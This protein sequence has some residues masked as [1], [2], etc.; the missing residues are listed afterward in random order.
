MSGLEPNFGEG[1]SGIFKELRA[2]KQKLNETFE[3]KVELSFDEKKIGEGVSQFFAAQLPAGKKIEASKHPTAFAAVNA[4]FDE[5]DPRRELM[6]VVRDNYKQLLRNKE[7]AGADENQLMD[8]AYQATVKGTASPNLEGATVEDDIHRYKFKRDTALFGGKNV[9][10]APGYDEWLQREKEKPIEDRLTGYGEAAAWWAGGDAAFHVLKKPVGNAIG[11]ALLATGV[12][13][14]QGIGGTLARVGPPQAKLL[15]TV[16]MAAAASVPATYLGNAVKKTDW[17]KAREDEPVKQA[18]TGI[19]VELLTGVGAMRG[20][21][22]QGTGVLKMAAERGAVTEATMRKFMSDQSASNI[23]AVAAARKAEKKALGE[24]SNLLTNVASKGERKAWFDKLNADDANFMKKYTDDYAVES[25]I[26]M[27]RN[28]LDEGLKLKSP[29]E[30]RPFGWEGEANQGTI[31][32][33]PAKPTIRTLSNFDDLGTPQWQ[34]EGYK[35]ATVNSKLD[36]PWFDDQIGTPLHQQGG[37]FEGYPFGQARETGT[38][39]A[40][41]SGQQFGLPAG[42]GQQMLPPSGVFGPKGQWSVVSRVENP[43]GGAGGGG[44]FGLSTKELP[45]KTVVGKTPEGNPIFGLNRKTQ[46]KI[47]KSL[48]DEQAVLVTDQ[49]LNGGK[50]LEEALEGM[51]KTR[52]LSGALKK[53]EDAIAVAKPKTTV[54]PPDNVIGYEGAGAAAESGKAAKVLVLKREAQEAG[55]ELASRAVAEQNAVRSS[56]EILREIGRG[57]APKGKEAMVLADDLADEAWDEQARAVLSYLGDKSRRLGVAVPE[58]RVAQLRAA[59]AK[60]VATPTEKVNPRTVRAEQKVADASQEMSDFQ[61]FT[62]GELD[63]ASYLKS[64][65]SPEFRAAEAEKI[66][67]TLAKAGVPDEKIDTHRAFETWR[68]MV[69]PIVEK[70]LEVI[71]PVADDLADFGGM[72]TGDS[73]ILKTLIPAGV[74]GTLSTAAVLGLPDDSHASVASAIGEAAARGIKAL[75]KAWFSTIAQSKKLASISHAES[76]KVFAKLIKEADEAGYVAKVVGT[77]KTLPRRM[78]TPNFAALAKE[79]YGSTAGAV[80]TVKALPLGIERLMG[81]WGRGAIHYNTGANPAVHLA[82]MQTAWTNNIENSFTVLHNIMK[83]VKGGA[84]A[85]REVAAMFK[86][87]AEEYSGVVTTHGIVTTKLRQL[88]KAL[89]VLEKAMKDPKLDAVAKEALQ[90]KYA[91]K[92]KELEA[93]NTA[94]R[95]KVGPAYEKFT[96]Q[97]EVLTKQAAQK[98]PSTRIFLAANDTADHQYYPWLKDLLT[99]EEKVAATHVKA[100]MK[101]YEESAVA[102]GLNVITDRPYMHY[103][104]HPSWQEARAAEYAKS[105][106][107]DLPVT[108]V[109][110]NQFHSRLVGAQPMV[111]DVYHSIQSYVPMAEKTLGWR[112]FWNKNGPKDSSWYKHMQS[113]TVQ[114][115]S[116][117]RG[118]WNAIKDASLPAEQMMVDKW[119]DRYTSFEVL[120]LLGG[121]PSVAY[122]HFFKNI[123]TWGSLGFKEAVSHMGTAVTTAARNKLMAPESAKYLSKLGIDTSKISKK[124]YDDAA[125]SFT[126]QARRINVL[127]DLELTP[128]SQVGWFDNMLQQVNHKAGFMVNA[129]ESYDRVHSFLAAGEMAAKRG[130]TGRDASYAI[131]DTILKNNFLGGV[132]NPSWAKSPLVRATMLFQSTA[133]K[134]FERRLITLHQSGRAVTEAFKSAKGTNWTWDKAFEEMKTLK[135]FIRKGEYEFKKGI[136]TDALASERDFLGQFSVRQSMREM[137]YAGVVLGGGAAMGHD[138]SHHIAHLPFVGTSQNGEP[139]VGLSPIAR[140]LWDTKEGKVYGGEESEFGI[141][142]DFLNNWF[143]GQ[144]PIPQMIHKGM[145]IAADDIPERYREEGFLPQEFRYFWAIP[146]TKEK[147]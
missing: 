87:L 110:Y 50:S 130:L 134:I 124:F 63:E 90:T 47:F 100:M 93:F 42:Q 131:Y 105:V 91:F 102:S 71:T 74:I 33:D 13:G 97:H 45:K 56:A 7:Y 1:D 92:L 18:L 126:N 144:G 9:A 40:L 109:P 79:L 60:G 83:D 65:E 104:W 99:S 70:E 127:D 68:K 140:A 73:S 106:G 137:L 72:T 96:A 35:P 34:G 117:M 76:Q 119:M 62:K 114:N 2:R 86:P 19:G 16:L 98:F 103:S 136:I 141:A 15:G 89:P 49:V 115:N 21:A 28:A 139:I 3:K 39:L 36:Q 6:P 31:F 133:F 8:L 122:K 120:R 29:V 57:I 77:S 5:D 135:D 67:N 107:I 85:A 23:M 138:Y 95:E 82:A 54:L 59:K 146:S 147:E 20:I 78:I 4:A 55:E 44:I 129:V 27:E 108:T 121:S 14:L 51:A 116:A 48:D 26:Q 53:T 22:K 24:M 81:P 88:N 38:Q 113:S 123:G 94:L 43:S 46:E 128:A 32:K 30:G 64:L 12:K 25:V 61:R 10:A 132:L 17:Y 37:A 66:Y 11:K 58:E 125:K 101:S 143:R 52:A 69:K 145:R 41:P 142:G 111:P 80:K 118:M 84:S 112:A 75:P